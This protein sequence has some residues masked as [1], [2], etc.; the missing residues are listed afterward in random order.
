MKRSKTSD[1]NASGPDTTPRSSEL[2]RLAERHLRFGWWALVLFA[3]LGIGLESLHG[4]KVGWYVDAS[5]E[6]ETRQMMWRLAHAHGTLLALIHLAFAASVAR[7]EAQDQRWRQIA[8]PCLY[9]A[10][11]TLP[12][13]FFLGGMFIYSGDPGVGIF[14]VPVGGFLLVIALG[15]IAQGVRSAGSKYKD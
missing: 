5:S 10:T 15:L 8:S 9:S 7:L 2:D 12:A 3:S 13:G 6:S 4:F 11:L 14:L 1:E